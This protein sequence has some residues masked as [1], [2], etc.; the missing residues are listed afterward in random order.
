M[1]NILQVVSDMLRLPIV[2]SAYHM[3]FVLYGQLTYHMC[4]FF[5]GQGSYNT[6]CVCH[7]QVP[8]FSM[9]FGIVRFTIKCVVSGMLRLPIIFVVLKWIGYLS[10]VLRPL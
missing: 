8:I 10:S 2:L 6:Y 4:C 7:G 9:V 1:H 3:C 5:H